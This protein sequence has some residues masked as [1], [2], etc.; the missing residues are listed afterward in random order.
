MKQRPVICS[1]QGLLCGTLIRERAD[2]LQ[3]AQ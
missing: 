3:L 2:L 1:L